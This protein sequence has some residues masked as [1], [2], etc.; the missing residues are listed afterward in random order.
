MLLDEMLEVNKS[1]KKTKTKQQANE[2]RDA[3]NDTRHN[4]TE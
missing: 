4:K 2:T 3:R 1:K